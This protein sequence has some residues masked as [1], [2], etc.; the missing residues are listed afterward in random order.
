MCPC[1]SMRSLYC[2][3]LFSATTFKS[4]QT[5]KTFKIYH[6]V[7]CKSNCNIPYVG[8]SETSFNIGLNNPKKH[9]KN[10]NAILAC[11]HFNRYDHDFNN[12]WKFIIIENLRNMSTKSTET[13]KERL[14]QWENLWIMEPENL[15]P[16]ELNQDLNWID[17]MQTFRSLQS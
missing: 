10:P 6:K 17:L 11:K 1:K 2:Q 3:Q 7:N 9:F 13:L 12:Q 5:N 16:P 15:A 4:T 14:K 8:N